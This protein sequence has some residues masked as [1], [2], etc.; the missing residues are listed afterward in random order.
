MAA[1]TGSVDVRRRVREE[2]EDREE[3][4]K[5]GG[6]DDGL[7]D[8]SQ[9]QKKFFRSR[10]H[11]NVLN[12]NSFWFPAKP[13]EVPRADYYPGLAAE[14]VLARRDI[15]F[16]DIGCGFGSLL[17]ELAALFPE[18]LMLGI[19]IRPKV[20]EYV[21]R[22]VLALR[23]E[24]RRRAAGG[25]AGAGGAGSAGSAGASTADAAAA[26]AATRPTAQP[27]T[28]AASAP[29]PGCENVWAVHNNA[30]RFMPNF[31]GKEQLS[32]LFFCFADPHF[33]K[34]NHRKRIVSDALLA[35]YAYV[36]QPGG[37]AYV[38]TDV[39]DLMTWIVDHF[40]RSPLFERLGRDELKADPAVPV[41]IRTD[42]GLK[43][44]RNNGNMFIAVFAKRTDPLAP[45]APPPPVDKALAAEA[46]AASDAGYTPKAG[47]ERRGMTW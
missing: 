38:I 43:V 32:K 16:V 24:S 34:K 20:V 29:S 2:E 26:A 45:R 40:L 42:E 21:Q 5:A 18:T 44:Q 25:E 22:R 28:A 41:L 39:A 15:E 12:A 37:R 13:S 19:E 7:E 11:S 46:E 47:G 3:E 14:G 33:K 8:F 4:E 9:P 31:F 36:M 23:Q 35:E 17:L 10:A 27:L 6:S 1:S 30:Q